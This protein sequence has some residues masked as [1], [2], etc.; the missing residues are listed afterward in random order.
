MIVALRAEGD[1][2]VTECAE[3]LTRGRRPFV[4]ATADGSDS[5]DRLVTEHGV[6]GMRA[7]FRRPDGTSFSRQRRALARRLGGISAEAPSADFAHVYRVALAPGSDPHAVA[8]RF[9]ADPHVAWAQP[10]HALVPDRLLDDPFLATQG[11]WGQSYPDQW[12]VYSVRAPEAWDA[13]LGAGVVVAVVDTGVDHT[14][15]DLAGN[16][17]VNPGEDLDGDGVAEASDRN[18]LDDDGNGYV[19]DLRGWDFQGDGTPAQNGFPVG[20]EDPM[21]ETGHGTHVAGIVAAR[22]DNGLAVAGIAPQATVLPVRVFPPVGGAESALVWQGVLYAA[23]NGADIVNA[24]FSCGAICR[25]APIAEAVL[26]VLAGLGVTY[27]TSA[28]NAGLDVMLKSPERLRESIVVGSL[29]PPPGERLSRF[30]SRGLL[31]DVVA[32]GRDVLSL[33]ASAAP[34]LFSAKRFVGDLAMRL[35]GTSMSAP[36]ASGVLALLLAE[37]PT[38]TPE[39]LRALLRATA[40][41]L[42]EPGHDPVYGAGALSAADALAAKRPPDLRGRVDRPLPGDTLDGTERVLVVEGSVAGRDVTEAVLELGIGDDPQR[43]L[44]LPLPAPLPSERAALTRL[45]VHALPD[46]AYLLRLTLR[47]GD[48]KVVRE[49]TPFSVDRNVPVFV[50]SADHAAESPDIH[51]R[52]VVWQSPRPGPDDGAE[53]RDLFAGVF[54]RTGERVLVAGPGDQ[55]DPALSAAALAWRG[56]G[57]P[58]TFESV[59]RACRFLGLRGR[60]APYDASPGAGFRGLP[61]L[62]G[63]GLVFGERVGGPPS[64]VACRVGLRDCRGGA[65][66]GVRGLSPVIDGLRAVWSQ[67]DGGLF[68][69]VLDRRGSCDPVPLPSTVPTLEPL[70]LERSWLVSLGFAANNLD[71]ALFVCEIS[72]GACDAHEVVSFPSPTAPAADLSGGRLVWHAPGAH[73]QDDVFLCELGAGAV[74]T[75]RPLTR[76]AARQTF[77]RIHGRRV[78]WVDD[79]DGVPRIASFELERRGR[80]KPVRGKGGAV[81]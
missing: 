8:R 76:D 42:G 37:D 52:R 77:P 79:R 23:I 33:A 53:Q 24:S 38:L 21:D 15:P 27:V 26:E 39:D 34:D 31:V 16:L 72:G 2:A 20:D 81:R 70:A 50:S 45:P 75:P 65:L 48:G 63:L 60:C 41:D 5:L 29:D 58:G 80:P 1:H 71:L 62:S 14:H 13:T 17:W 40:R 9:G 47:A 57:A 19:D 3:A 25:D 73:G 35:D 32:P 64:I 7:V 36:H 6:R 55:R 49:F 69:C 4:G 66:E 78:V 10:N 59:V 61:R 18:G 68:G 51:D 11:S 54:G 43:W 30:S 28:G 46:E 56:P 22:G 44:P 12:G 74:C 67:P